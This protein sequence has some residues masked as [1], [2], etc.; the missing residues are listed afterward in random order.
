MKTDTDNLEAQGL[1]SL[2]TIEQ[3]IQHLPYNCLLNTRTGFSFRT[4]SAE[5]TTTHIHAPCGK[6]TC[7]YCAHRFYHQAHPALCQA[8]HDLGLQFH[9]TLT[10]PGTVTADQQEPILKQAI[11][12]LVQDVRRSFKTTL[13]FFWVIG[14]HAS[15]S[16]HA[17]MLLNI[18]IRRGSRYG[19]R[20]AWL[21]DTWYRLTGG[22]QVKSKEIV[23]GTEER[24]VQY[25]LL[26]LFQT[27]VRERV[28]GRRY[29]SSRSIRLRRREKRSA[30]SAV[31]YVRQRQPTGMIARN[32]GLDPYPVMNGKYVVAGKNNDE[33]GTTSFEP[34]RAEAPLRRST[35]AVGTTVPA[36]AGGGAGEPFKDVLEAVPS[37]TNPDRKQ[38]G[39]DRT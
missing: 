2:N 24:V 9:V 20:T 1:D 29:G 4:T 22:Y 7:R 35:D 23:P 39:K 26:N 38:T 31:K 33:V 17:H 15:G 34:G 25:L 30:D 18:D 5:G 6:L 28:A 14:T 11:Q 12:R 27:V 16:L 36:G 8:F 13:H 3:I 37:G 21:K 19:R 32:R 10:L